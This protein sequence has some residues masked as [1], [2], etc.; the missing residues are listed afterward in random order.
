MEKMM[1][2]SPVFYVLRS[3]LFLSLFLPMCFLCPLPSDLRFQCLSCAC[4]TAFCTRYPSF[5]LL[6]SVM[7]PPQCLRKT[8]ESLLTHS[9][10]LI[11]YSIHFHSFVFN[12]NDCIWPPFQLLMTENGWVPL[13]GCS[14]QAMC[15]AFHNIQLYSFIWAFFQSSSTYQFKRSYWMPTLWSHGFEF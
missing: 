8:S 14:F 9:I 15:G 11:D 1:N 10:N 12:F 4:H 2:S 3:L 7:N 5:L 13:L 6:H